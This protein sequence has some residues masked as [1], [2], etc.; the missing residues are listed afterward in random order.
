MVQ[1]IGILK[2]DGLKWKIFHPET[3][4]K[5]TESYQKHIVVRNCVKGVSP[6]TDAAKIYMVRDENGVILN[7]SNFEQYTEV[8]SVIVSAPTQVHQPSPVK[9]SLIKEVA[10]AVQA[11]PAARRAKSAMDFPPEVR[12]AFL[13][14]FTNMV[15][16]RRVN[17][18]LVGGKGGVCKS[19]TV[20][21]QFAKRGMQEA[22]K[23]AT[24]MR[25]TMNAES[26]RQKNAKK[27]RGEK[28]DDD[29]DVQSEDDSR[30]IPVHS[31]GDY[32]VI[33][34]KC[35][36][37]RAYREL[38]NY[39]DR[40]VVFDDCDSVLTSDDTL[41]VFKGALDTKEQRIVSWQA[42]AKLDETL[43]PFFEFKGT[44]IFITNMDLDD[45]DG[46]VKSRCL[47]Y[48]LPMTKD[49]ALDVIEKRLPSVLPQIPIENRWGVL[50]FLR[51]YKE[52]VKDLNFRTFIKVCQIRAYNE[53]RWEDKAMIAIRS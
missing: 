43:P 20:E 23:V 45:I 49:E 36:P 26:L 24:E 5:L 9:E 44:V 25:E 33:T 46:A 17:A 30:I 10:P 53:N 16:E 22:T 18:L 34:G 11:I 3:K 39:R 27:A 13:E 47:P 35:T 29:E 31:Y 38:F 15:I 21:S 6:K 19:F 8:G 14:E 40:C 7:A 2:R 50:R 12:L 51:D 1:R 41:M 4:K 48:E 42:E 32:I 52:D 28:V 37:K